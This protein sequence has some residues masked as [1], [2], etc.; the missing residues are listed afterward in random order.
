MTVTL[1]PEHGQ[2]LICPACRGNAREVHAGFCRCPDCG[3]QGAIDDTLDFRCRRPPVPE[4][5]MPTATSWMRD[6]PALLAGGDLSS[7]R[8]A[9]I[10]RELVELAICLQAVLSSP[11]S[12]PRPHLFTDCKDRLA[13]FHETLTAKHLTS[14]R[15]Q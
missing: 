12:S 6:L 3:W 11:T 2:P 14:E 8:R 13:A 1:S 9:I 5:T 15:D 7:A 4:P 10:H